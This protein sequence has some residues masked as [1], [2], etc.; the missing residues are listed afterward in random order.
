MLFSA[1]STIAMVSYCVTKMR[2]CRTIEQVSE[3]MIV[4]SVDKKWL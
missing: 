2:M 4:A 3:T 1:G